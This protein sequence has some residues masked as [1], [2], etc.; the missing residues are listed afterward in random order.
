[1]CCI[2]THVHPVYTAT[3]LY[4]F[5]FVVIVALSNDLFTPHVIIPG[6][7][8]AGDNFNIICRLDG[9]VKRLVSTPA[10]LLIFISPPGGVS[11]DQSRDG[12]AYIRPRIFNPGKTS[13]VG[14]YI[15]G[16]SVFLSSGLF[17]DTASGI[18]QIQSNVPGIMYNFIQLLC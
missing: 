2:C 15:C 10:V 12:S 5:D 4:W 7:P 11:G 17:G 9:I 16:A 3:R 13:D 6:T 1:M 18:L 8:T 14:T